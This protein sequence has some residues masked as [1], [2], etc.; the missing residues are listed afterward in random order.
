V[1]LDDLLRDD[2]AQGRSNG[3]E[4]GRHLC[5]FADGKLFGKSW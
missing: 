2:L 1:L 3:F 4:F 5:R